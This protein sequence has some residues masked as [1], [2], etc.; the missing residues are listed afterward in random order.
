MLYCFTFVT[1]ENVKNSQHDLLL[2]GWR[3]SFM[4]WREHCLQF[5]LHAHAGSCRDPGMLPYS[6]AA[7]NVKSRWAFS[8]NPSVES[9]VT[10]TSL[11]HRYEHLCKHRATAA[12][13]RCWQTVNTPTHTHTH[14]PKQCAAFKLLLNCLLVLSPPQ[15]LRN[16]AEHQSGP[17]PLPKNRQDRLFHLLSKQKD[18]R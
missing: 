3:Q 12:K 7:C 14:N 13:H 8:V 17:P 10:S 9:A 11:L 15:P 4:V 18:R 16:H 5:L 2:T 6:L 1:E